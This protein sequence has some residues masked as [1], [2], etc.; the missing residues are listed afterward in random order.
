MSLGVAAPWNIRISQRVRAR[1]TPHLSRA[2]A[3]TATATIT[4]ARA[5]FIM[6]GYFGNRRREG[7]ALGTATLLPSWVKPPTRPPVQRLLDFPKGG[8]L[9]F[10]NTQSLLSMVTVTRGAAGKEGKGT[11]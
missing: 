2:A 3:A 4:A 1:F 5:F 8:K 7:G 9:L 10:F 11:E 6:D